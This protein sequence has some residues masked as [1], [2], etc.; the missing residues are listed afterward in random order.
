MSRATLVASRGWAGGGEADW[1]G[2]DERERR[3]WDV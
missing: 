3:A 1:E 2:E